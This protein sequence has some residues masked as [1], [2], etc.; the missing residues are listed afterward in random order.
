[1]QQTSLQW[2]IIPISTPPKNFIQLYVDNDTQFAWKKNIFVTEVEKHLVLV[3]C[4][5][6]YPR[7]AFVAAIALAIKLSLS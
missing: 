1:M 6:H 2:E 4:R 7:N 3:L 5:A